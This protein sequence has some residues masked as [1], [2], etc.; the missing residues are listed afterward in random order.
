MAF[1][2]LA[3]ALKLAVLTD[4][5]EPAAVTAVEGLS[6]RALQAELKVRELTID[7]TTLTSQLAAAVAARDVALTSV[8]DAVIADGYATGKLGYGKD[9]KGASTPDAL[10]SMLRD[11]GASKGVDQV[12][13]KLTAMRT[14]IPVGE[15]V[16]SA[17]A[18]DAG[19]P[20]KTLLAHQDAVDAELKTASEQLGVTLEKL[21]EQRKRMGGR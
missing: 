3:A 1:S 20:P 18:P 14:S 8:L 17:A 7:K 15:R 21:R 12:K 10:E 2:R 4:A 16:L 9:E 6:A 13:A 19:A 5:D 11:L